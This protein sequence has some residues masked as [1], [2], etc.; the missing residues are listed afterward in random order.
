MLLLCRTFGEISLI[1]P[2]P[3]TSYEET[4]KCA[5]QYP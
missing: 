5:Q 4:D 1:C 3:N 2:L